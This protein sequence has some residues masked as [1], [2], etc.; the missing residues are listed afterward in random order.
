M[1]KIGQEK[2]QCEIG[3]I[4]YNFRKKMGWTQEKV[5]TILG[6]DRSAYCYYESGKV[7]PKMDCFLQL[8]VLYG[9]SQK[10]LTETL[11]GTE[12][13]RRVGMR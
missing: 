5:A 10:E 11:R 2:I 1:S 12:Q 4:F 3:Q 8:V 6:I 13:G 9:I 7:M